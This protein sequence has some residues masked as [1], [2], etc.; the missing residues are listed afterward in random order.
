MRIGFDAVGVEV[1]MIEDTV[2]FRNRDHGNIAAVFGEDAAGQVRGAIAVIDVG[3]G[4][5]PL[6]DLNFL[7][8]GNFAGQVI[9]IKYSA[10]NNGDGNQCQH[11]APV[12]KR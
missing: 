9:G 10:R 5:G 6:L 3:D 12:G 1:V 8:G 11:T 4:F 7:I 2:V